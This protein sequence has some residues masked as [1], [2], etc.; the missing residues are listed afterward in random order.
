MR[1]KQCLQAA[2][3][4]AWFNDHYWIKLLA[5]LSFVFLCIVRWRKDFLLAK[6]RWEPPV[7]VV[8]V[9]NISVGGVGKTPVVACLAKGMQAR[10]YKPGIVS[11]GFGGAG[12]R[13]PALVTAM[14]SP[15]DVGD[16][17]VMLAQQLDIPVVVDPNRVNAAYFL[18]KHHE[19]N[20][21]IA[22]D[23]L[24]HYNLKRNV[25]LLVID[26]HRMFGN[27]LCLPAG[28]LR[29]PEGRLQS[30]DL[31]LI[32]GEP[33]F[34]PGV[35]Y[36]SFKLLPQALMAVRPDSR[37]FTAVCPQGCRVHGVAGIGN[38]ERFFNTLADLG[39]EVV[40]HVFPD[41]YCYRAEDIV[42][43]EE[44][45]VIMTAKDAVKCTEFAT[46][47]HWYLPVATNISAHVLDHI[48]SLIE[49]SDVM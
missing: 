42:F 13:Y 31:V 22:D 34:D 38:P 17:P 26:G 19:C 14:S 23:G 18:L 41:H 25:E 5:P 49:N 27:G 15:K 4:R 9:G 36:H 43:E 48:A 8:V 37:N 33:A 3:L 30:V 28:P 24:Q 45:P 35:S 16:E 32:N 46:P 39:F 20:L 2:V 7:P 10:G 40:V 29:E 6:K 21:I 1:V 47:N 44:L 12:A 11:R